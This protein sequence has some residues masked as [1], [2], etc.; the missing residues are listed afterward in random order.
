M[1]KNII[2]V[3]LGILVIIISVAIVFYLSQETLRIH[4]VTTLKWIPMLSTFIGFYFAG[5]ITKKLK[6]KY[7]G[8]LLFTL[9]IFIPVRYFYFPFIIYLLFFAICGII[10]SRTKVEK[11]TKII[12]SFFSVLFFSFFLFNQ[13]LIIEQERFGTYPDG[14]LVNAKQIWNFSSYKPKKIINE[15]FINLE[16]E[17]IELINFK[18]KTIYISFWATWC[19]PCI[20]EKPL[21]DKLKEQFKE[22]TEII[23]IDISLDKDKIRWKSYLEKNKPE[24]IQLLSKNESLTRRNFELNGIPSH[25]IVNNKNQYK[26]LRYIPAAKAYLENEELLNK[27]L[28]SER[29]IIEKTE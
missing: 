27:W 25:I 19:A 1:K 15:S 7:V 18:G 5:I 2:K 21:L 11:K 3:I 4:K 26:S 29:L 24:G 9:L 17:K 23:F 28:E 14:T 6:L 13:P 16:N 20:A 12:I 22:N 10:L 8:I